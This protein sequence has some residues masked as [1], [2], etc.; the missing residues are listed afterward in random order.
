MRRVR[1]VTSA[2]LT[3]YSAAS[4]NSSHLL[5]VLV[6]CVELFRVHY[7]TLTSVFCYSLIYRAILV[8]CWEYTMYWVQ[9]LCLWTL[10]IVLFLL[11]TK[12][13]VSETGEDIRT[14]SIEWDQLSRFRRK[15]ETETSLRNVVF[16]FK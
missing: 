5:Q 13:E 9:L 4:S 6:N 1:H 3:M 15:T 11:K 16:R 2:G 12:H 7:S 14:G 8:A 10:S